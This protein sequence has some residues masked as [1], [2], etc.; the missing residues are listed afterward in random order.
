MNLD[1]LLRR[2]YI[3][4]TG[5]DTTS[6]NSSG[7]NFNKDGSSNVQRSGLG[8]FSS[9]SLF[10]TLINMKFSHFVLMAF[11]TFIGVNFI[12][13]ALYF[14]LGAEQIT[15]ISGTTPIEK[16]LSCFFF[17]AQT[18][19]TVGYG[20]M[21]PNTITANA[22]STFE[23]VFGWM[24]FAVLTGLIYG[25]FSKPRAYLMFSECALISPYKNGKAL[26]FRMAPYKNNNLTEVEV[27]LNLAIRLE[28]NGMLVNK[29]LPLQVE[30]PKITALALNWTVVHAINEESPFYNM[31][32]NEFAEKSVEVL[33]FVKAFDE[34]FSNIVKQRTSYVAGDIIHGAKFDLMFK[35][36]DNKKS[37]LLELD[38]ISDYHKVEL[39]VS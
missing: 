1:S 38:K 19:T 24:A 3:N 39:P 17:S 7:R 35:Q 30:L 28:E 4:N 36:S 18:I 11:A 16:F 27:M 23:A 37:T 15:G 6:G 21:H 25:R 8:Y 29:F 9:I 2:N 14:A 33:I 5:L 22:L 34:H 31:S 32:E 12:F 13:A 10:H 26:M 20:Q